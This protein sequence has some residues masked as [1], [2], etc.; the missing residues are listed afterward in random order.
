MQTRQQLY[1]TL[2][3]AAYEH[4]DASIAPSSAPK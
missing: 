4:L 1:D 3:Y 2:G